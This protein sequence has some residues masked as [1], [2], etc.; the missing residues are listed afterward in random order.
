MEPD[1]ALEMLSRDPAR[2]GVF[3]DFDG[4]L[5]RIVDRPEDAVPWQG[6]EA[7]LERLAIELAVVAVISGRALG[8]LE[9]RFGASG[10]IVAASYGRQ[11]SDRSTLGLLRSYRWEDVADDAEAAVRSMPG[12]VVE[13]KEA[14]VALHYRS[15]PE[16]SAAVHRVADDI[17]R[18]HGMEVQSGRMVA[19]LIAPG[20]GKGDALRELVDEHEVERLMYAGDDIS[21][22]D[23]LRWARSS[24]KDCVLIG[25]GSE[26][27]PAELRSAADLLVG[28]PE[29]VVGF[30]ERLAE[31]L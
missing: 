7:V 12:V 14:G 29:E 20:P 1:A 28:G 4:T 19:E 2:T 18:R 31:R 30:L 16:R 27:A 26:E 22:L 9:G 3:C 15:D 13:R 8:D 10:V 21:D 23:A 17:A 6:A 11:R 24:G 5:A 25:V